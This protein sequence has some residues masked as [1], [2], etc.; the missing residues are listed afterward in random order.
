[1]HRSSMTGMSGSGTALEHYEAA[2]DASCD[3]LIILQSIHAALAS[4][5]TGGAAARRQIRRAIDSQRRAIAELRKAKGE[6]ENTPV[7]GFVLDTGTD[8][9]R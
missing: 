3:T 7:I 8:L 1:M 4:S 6:P 5:S 2:L 9:P